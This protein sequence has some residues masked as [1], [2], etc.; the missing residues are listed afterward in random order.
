MKNGFRTLV[1][2]RHP[3]HNILRTSLERLPFRSVV[4]LGSTTVLSKKCEAKGAYTE[5]NSIKGIINT[6]N[7]LIMK[8]K[9]IES[10]IPSPAMF[11]PLIQPSGVGIGTETKDGAIAINVE[12]KLKYVVSALGMNGNSVSGNPIKIIDLQYPLVAKVNFHSRGRGMLLLKDVEAL[13]ELLKQDNVRKYTFEK[14]TNF[15]Q[16]YRVHATRDG[17]F[18]ICRKLRK[19]E[20]TDRWYFNSKNSVFQITY[21][22]GVW[23]KPQLACFKSMEQACIK[24][25]IALDMDIA[26]FD[27]RVNASG[28]NFL[29]IEANSACSFG[30]HTA[31]QYI[32]QIPIILKKKHDNQNKSS[33][34]KSTKEIPW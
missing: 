8:M 18:Y 27:I 15:A 21:E 25:L 9:F 12:N 34:D 33:K 11:L 20:A 10:G 19:E 30:E 23:I 17:I 26:G 6:S 14:Y 32:K 4:R 31:Q 13:K 3:T 1:Y 28:E 22:D 24:A 2:S 16:E 5:C 29:I 7:K